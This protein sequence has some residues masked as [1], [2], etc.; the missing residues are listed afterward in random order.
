M[1]A[2]EILDK[3]C[4]NALC[5]EVLERHGHAIYA[6]IEEICDKHD[7]K[8]DFS[9]LQRASLLHDIGCVRVRS[10][11]MGCYGSLPYISHGVEGAKIMRELGDEACARVCECHIGAGLSREDIESENIALPPEDYLPQSL[12]EQLICYADNFYSK[13][14]LQLEVRAQWQEIEEEARAW[15]PRAQSR[16][17]ALHEKF[18]L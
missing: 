17:Q 8:P 16:L 15:G 2:K 1:N 4:P 13:N 6:M 5:R 18:R 14:P 7:L 12:E 11:R 9:F 10:P 3:Y